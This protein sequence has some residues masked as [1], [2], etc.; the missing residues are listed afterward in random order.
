MKGKNCFYSPF[1]QMRNGAEGNVGGGER[2]GWRGESQN[3]DFVVCWVCAFNHE[4][5]TP[6]G[7]E[8]IRTSSHPQPQLKPQESLVIS[9]KEGILGTHMSVLLF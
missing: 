6:T 2:W 9:G 3:V 4:E 7:L 5:L 8:F 1:F